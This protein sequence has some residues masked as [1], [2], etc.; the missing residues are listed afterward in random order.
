MHPLETYYL[1]QAGRSLSPT[2]GIGPIYSVPLYLQ[3]GH[4]IGNFLGSLFRFVRPLQCTVHAEDIISKHV[5]DVTESTHRLI[6]KLH[7]RCLKR[8]RRETS[9]GRVVKK[10]EM[11][12]AKRTRV[13]KG[14]T[15]S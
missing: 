12:P 2:S 8:V 10:S 11:T 6:S 14:D 7:V 13:T 9:K 5:G 15:F 4:G 3:R 1:K